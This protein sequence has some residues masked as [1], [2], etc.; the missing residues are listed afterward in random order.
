MPNL[1][2]IGDTNNGKTS[3]LNRLLRL[4]PADDNIDGDAKIIPLIR[5]Q[6]PSDADEGAFYNLI[7]RELG[8]PFRPSYRSTVKYIQITTVVPQIGLRGILIDEIHDIL[9]GNKNKQK[10]FQCIIRQLGNELKIPI[11][12]AGAMNALSAINSD[13]QLANRFTTV[14]IPKWKIYYLKKADKEPFLRLLASFET[15]LPL[16]EKSDLT[17]MEIAKKLLTMSEGLIGE[18]A[19]ILGLAVEKA[20]NDGKE[21][22]DLELLNKMSWIYPSDRNKVRPKANA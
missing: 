20:I 6:A 18:L 11:I 8:V 10:R 22:I 1:L 2:I 9:V 19:S 7:L 21:K 3:I 17:N 5:V 16:V 15:K 14:F 12:A 13:P 4:H